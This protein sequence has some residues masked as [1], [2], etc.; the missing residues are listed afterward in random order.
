MW[1]NVFVSLEA[2]NGWTSVQCLGVI[3][4]NI[5]VM[6]VEKVMRIFLGMTRMFQK[7]D[8]CNC[9]LRNAASFV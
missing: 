4:Y 9:P 5:L 6:V 7:L 8:M 3:V 2:R 1:V